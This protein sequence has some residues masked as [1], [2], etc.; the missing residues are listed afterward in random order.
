MTNEIYL[1]ELPKWEQG[2]NKGRINWNEAVGC[3]INFI[4]DSSK[5][6][7]E[8]IKYNK[9]KQQ[10]TIKYNENI[11]D[12]NTNSLQ[13]CNLGKIIGKFTSDFKIEIGTIYKDEKRDIIITDR[14]YK[15][16]KGQKW[17]YY[18]YTCNKCRWTEGYIE[19]SHLFGNK[20]QGCACCC[21]SPRIVVKGINDIPTT[22][23]WMIPY[24]QGGYDEAKLYTK[25]N[26]K[27]LYFKCPD[28]GRIS[29][30]KMRIAD[31]YQSRSC[32]CSCGDGISYPNKLM[33][34]I[35]E[36]LNIEFTSE[37]NP[38]WIK[39]KLYDF[40]IS[41]MNL[42]IEMDGSLG[43][44]KKINALNGQTKEE[45]KAIDIYKDEQ[46]KLHNIEVIRIDCDYDSVENRFEY[47]KQSIIS[48]DRFNKLFDLYCINWEKA[49]EFACSN[50]VKVVCDY[51]KNNPNITTTEIS[52]LTELN[53]VTIIRYLKI[54]TKLGWCN[55][56]S[57]EEH[58]KTLMSNGTKNGKKF[59]KQ[60]E[61]FKDGK[62][63]GVFPSCAELERKS[64]ELFGTKL[65]N[66]QISCVCNINSTRHRNEYKGFTFKYVS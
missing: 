38:D 33:F 50:L 62:S 11:F 8:V 40:Y 23:S 20:Q 13:K 49:N 44:G 34:N 66:S 3:K 55:Y 60:V 5:G 4:Y 17:K 41:F 36:Q 12:I 57:R 26:S 37:Y 45:S 18:K 58:L 14:I 42:I 51:K 22:A 16:K 56:N 7:I 10:L 30:T 27:K 64:E 63:L 6:V 1:D 24:F 15:N 54:G 53:I 21:P 48:N 25:S 31:L 59:S 19:E 61:I 9:L 43:H 65:D 28:C 52:K 32:A 35:L 39:P 29:R 46:A 47:I 2:T